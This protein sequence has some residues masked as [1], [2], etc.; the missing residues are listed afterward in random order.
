MDPKILIIIPTCEIARRAD[1]YDYADAIHRPEGTVQ[2]R[3]HGQSP[4]RNRNMAIQQGLDMECTH[5][6][7]LDDDVVPRPDALLRLLAHDKDMV[8]GLYLMRNYPHLPIMFDQS[9]NDGRCLFSFLRPG[10]KGLVEAVNTGLGCALIKAEV[11]KKMEKPWIRI[12]QLEK[13]HWC[14]DIDFF[15]RAR[16]DYGFKLYVDLEVQA[17]HMIHT[18]IFPHRDAEGT[19]HTAYTTNQNEAFTVPQ[20]WPTDEV[21][22]KEVNGLGVELVEKV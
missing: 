3:P 6:F 2:I 8:S 15:N 13:D 11:F 17:G 12:G 9:F 21:I 19:W 5:F 4:A 7:F 18:T 22:E 20:Q 10:R 14:D 16:N 1:F